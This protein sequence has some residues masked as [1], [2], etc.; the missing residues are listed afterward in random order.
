[1]TI[2]VWLFSYNLHDNF[3][4]YVPLNVQVKVGFFFNLLWHYFIFIVLNM[5]RWQKRRSFLFLQIRKEFF[6]FVK[7]FLPQWTRSTSATAKRSSQKDKT[8]VTSRVV[9][10]QA[11]VLYCCHGPRGGGLETLKWINGRLNTSLCI[12]LERI[13]HKENKTKNKKERTKVNHWLVYLQ[14]IWFLINILN[15]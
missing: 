1:M 11:W 15:W 7:F 14:I 6:F 8:I 3:L 10:R 12:S 2:T 5:K 9:L 13:Q 4:P